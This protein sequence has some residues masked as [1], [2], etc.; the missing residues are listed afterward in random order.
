MVLHVNVAAGHSRGPAQACGLRLT[1]LSF[2]TPSTFVDLVEQE[3]YVDSAALAESQLE[4]QEERAALGLSNDPTPA[5]EVDEVDDWEV[6]NLIKFI[7]ELRGKL[8]GSE[9]FHT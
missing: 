2:V 5:I 9:R 4:L 7:G 3:A 1:A 6:R 8:V